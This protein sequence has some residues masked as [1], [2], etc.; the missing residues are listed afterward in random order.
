MTGFEHEDLVIDV[1][2]DETAVVRLDW[3]GKSNAREPAKVLA[4]FFDSVLDEAATG[5]HTVEMHFEDIDHFNSSTITAIIQL[6]Q[7]ARKTETPLVIV[8]DPGL[9]W[10]KLSFD[11][12]KVFQK[13]DGL[14]TIR[15]VN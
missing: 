1:A 5:K 12:L 11:A 7:R 6:I 14:L 15:E 2:R 13:P 4:P 8:F 10:Q 9:K 3:K